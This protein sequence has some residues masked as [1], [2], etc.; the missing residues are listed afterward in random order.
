VLHQQLGCFP[1]AGDE[2][3]VV[4]LDTGREYAYGRDLRGGGGVLCSVE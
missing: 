4:L 1:V 3:D 2:L